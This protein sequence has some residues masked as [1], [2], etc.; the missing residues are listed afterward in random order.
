MTWTRRALRQ[1][2]GEPSYL[3]D[4][5]LSSASANSTLGYDLIDTSLKHADDSFIGGS[6][7]IY[8]GTYE[9]V[10]RVVT[11]WVQST[12]TFTVDRTFGGNIA[13]AVTYEIHRRFPAAEKIKAINQAVRDSKWKWARHIEDTSLAL[14]ADT[15]TYSLA[16]LSIGVDF[17]AGI[18]KIEYDPAG[19]GTG[20]LWEEI[21][22]TDW[23][24]RN[25]N[26]VLTL[27][28]LGGVPKVGASLRLTYRARPRVFTAD[29]GANVNTTVGTLDV[30]N[31]AFAGYV[32][33]RASA[34][35]CAWR[36]NLQEET[37]SRDHWLS[38]ASMFQA[39]A[40][41]YLSDDKEDMRPRRRDLPARQPEQGA[42]PH[43][44]RR[45]KPSEVL[46]CQTQLP[47]PASPTTS[48]LPMAI[49]TTRPN[50]A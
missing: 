13:S 4:V 42:H 28:L 18:D 40:D 1:R 7:Y 10:E 15:Y 19:S 26:D 3:G 9:N 36:S 43:S 49:Q 12:G 25:S 31:E 5:I 38:R 39:M 37:T 2:I 17:I 34:I 27:Q 41:G 24:I 29:T 6:I 14:I 30:D 46:T 22:N 32:C 47:L 23:T 8:S 50:R 45:P 35:L 20:Y 11:D 16:N 44:R 48:C 33:A 21:H